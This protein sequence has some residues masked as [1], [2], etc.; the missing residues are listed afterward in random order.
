MWF[1]HIKRIPKDYVVR[2]IDKIE[3]NQIT[4]GIR[5]LIKTI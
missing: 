1:G 2:R 5:R 4:R 3:D